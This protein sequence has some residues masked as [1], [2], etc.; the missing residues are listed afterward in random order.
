M[1]TEQREQRRL[2]LIA[3]RLASPAQLVAIYRTAHNLDDLAPLP[4]TI[5]IPA[6]IEAILDS[7]EAGQID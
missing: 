1:R 2:E 3:I 5:T 4:D 6:I 7:E